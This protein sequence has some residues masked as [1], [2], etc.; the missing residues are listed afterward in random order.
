[1]NVKIGM[2]APLAAMFMGPIGA[3]SGDDEP[4]SGVSDR[5][6]Y[7]PPELELGLVQ[8]SK[9]AGIL[10]VPMGV[11]AAIFGV[12]LQGFRSDLRLDIQKVVTDAIDKHVEAERVSYATLS[13]ASGLRDEVVRIHKENDEMRRQIRANTDL[14]QRVAQKVGVH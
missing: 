6:R 10:F 12:Y 4:F 2:L 14:L 11:I 3:G 1:M 7:P 9:I 5:R 8:A 13:E